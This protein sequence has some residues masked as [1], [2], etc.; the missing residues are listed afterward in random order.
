M[1]GFLTKERLL[2]FPQRC[3]SRKTADLLHF[4]LH[5]VLSVITVEILCCYNATPHFL[6][7]ELT[8]GSCQLYTWR[9]NI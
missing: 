3:T 9:L 4:M 7:D 2:S 1:G 8:C 5:R 6:R